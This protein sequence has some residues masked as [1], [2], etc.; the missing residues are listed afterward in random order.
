LVSVLDTHTIPTCVT[1]F[2]VLKTEQDFK[3]T[4]PMDHGS[5]A[6]NR[7]NQDVAAIKLPI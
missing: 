3:A 2:N 1:T 6:L 7:L 5:T 4:K